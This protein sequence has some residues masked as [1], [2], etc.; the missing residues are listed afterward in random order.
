MPIEIGDFDIVAITSQPDAKTGLLPTTRVGV[1]ARTRP[2]DVIVHLGGRTF[3]SYRRRDPRL[4]LVAKDEPL[5]VQAE[6][7]APKTVNL[8]LEF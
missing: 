1:V 2:A 3:E 6:L 7:K 4:A 8:R 5:A